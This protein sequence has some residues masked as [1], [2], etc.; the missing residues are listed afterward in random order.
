MDYINELK[1]EF[2]NDMIKQLKEMNK[3][4]DNNNTDDNIDDDGI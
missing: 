4:T 2:L 1:V 3:L